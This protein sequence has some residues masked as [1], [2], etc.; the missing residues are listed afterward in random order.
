MPPDA[1]QWVSPDALVQ[2]VGFPASD[3]ARATRGAAVAVNGLV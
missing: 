1:S 3:A 2:V